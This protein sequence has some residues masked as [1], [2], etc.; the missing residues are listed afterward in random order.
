MFFA[1]FGAK[2]YEFRPKRSKVKPRGCRITKSRHKIDPKGSRFEPQG[3]QNETKWCQM[4]PQS[5]SQ[6]EEIQLKVATTKRSIQGGA[7]NILILVFFI[8]KCIR[9]SMRKTMPGKASKII[10]LQKK[11]R[12]DSIPRNAFTH[13][14]SVKAVPPKY[15]VYYKK[16]VF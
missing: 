13:C 8:N 1:D 10:Q 16:N 11:T 15:H 9:K 4:D 12:H 6:I 5:E 3:H 14:S 2:K 7:S